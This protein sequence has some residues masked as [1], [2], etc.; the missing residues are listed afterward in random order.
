MIITTHIP[1][2]G[3]YNSPKDIFVHA[4]GEYINGEHAVSFLAN[5]VS[6]NRRSAHSL[7]APD[8]TNYRL[9]NDNEGAWHAG[10]FNTDSLGIEFLVPGMFNDYASF[11]D[12]IKNDYVTSESYKAGR[13]QI[14]EW[15]ELYPIRTIKRHS[16]VSPGRK[17]DPGEG[18]PWQRL[19]ND[20]GM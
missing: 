10:G 16:D 1:H 7:I 13:E 19:L 17:Q 18:F 14:E 11:L 4:M 5:G 8:G 3:K 9:R 20:V 6:P 2:G 15:I 12:A